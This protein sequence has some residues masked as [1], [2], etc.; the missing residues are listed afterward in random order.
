MYIHTCR[1]QSRG[2]WS[3]EGIKQDDNPNTKVTCVTTHL[4]SF[5]VLVSARAQAD[6]ELCCYT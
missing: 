2:G 1:N 5:S 6:R 4:T 3:I